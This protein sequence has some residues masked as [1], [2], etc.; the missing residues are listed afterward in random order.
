MRRGGLGADHSKCSPRAWVPARGT[1]RP[2]PCLNPCRSHRKLAKPHDAQIA[3]QGRAT[4]RDV[5][6]LAL[7]I[8]QVRQAP[9]D[10]AIEIELAASF[11]R[12]GQSLTPL[13][14]QVRRLAK[15]FACPECF[16]T[17]PIEPRNLVP[18]DMQTDTASPRRTRSRSTVQENGDR[19]KAAFTRPSITRLPGASHRGS[20]PPRSACR[21]S[22]GPRASDFAEVHRSPGHR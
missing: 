3:A 6:F 4:D 21:S 22:P 8:D 7:P 17:A 1:T 18:G 11:D 20:A 10:D 16:W 13:V 19:K 5:E 9:P 12:A 15:C 2:A 14:G